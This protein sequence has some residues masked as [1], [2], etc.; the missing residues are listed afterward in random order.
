MWFFFLH[1]RLQ[2]FILHLIYLKVSGGAGGCAP[3]WLYIF[4]NFSRP[5]P[6]SYSL[7]YISSSSSKICRAHFGPPIP[8]ETYWNFQK[9]T[10]VFFD[11]LK[12]GR[13]FLC[14]GAVNRACRVAPARLSVGQWALL[15]ICCGDRKLF[16]LNFN[17]SY[18]NPCVPLRPFALTA[19]M[20]YIYIYIVFI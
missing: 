8:F 20:A 3:H 9:I 6:P 1:F 13:F 2:L 17:L 11:V 4:P 16:I 15:S 14:A 19:Y 10:F 18:I 5:P 7:L 12:K